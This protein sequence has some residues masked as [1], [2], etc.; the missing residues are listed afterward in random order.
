VACLY[1]GGDQHCSRSQVSDISVCRPNFPKLSSAGALVLGVGIDERNRLAYA[2][3]TSRL[4]VSAFQEVVMQMDNIG[5]AS[6]V[7]LNDLKSVHTEVDRLL[8][9]TSMQSNGCA[10]T[11]R[12]AKPCSQPRTQPGEATEPTP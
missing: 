4:L 1:I 3:A 5:D 12:L 6:P 11:G 2:R 8:V 10:L 7:L 9:I